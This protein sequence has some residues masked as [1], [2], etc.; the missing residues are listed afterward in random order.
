MRNVATL[1][2]APDKPPPLTRPL[3]LS[4]VV[5]EFPSPANDYLD[6]D[7]DLHELLIQRPAAGM[8]AN[9]LHGFGRVMALGQSW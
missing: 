6:R 1:Y 3:F 5:A 7:L 8:S 2:S 4:L 9:R